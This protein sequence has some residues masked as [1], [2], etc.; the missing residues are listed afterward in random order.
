MTRWVDG[1]EVDS[2]TTPWSLI[3]KSES[4]ETYGSFRR[5][6]VKKA[7]RVDFFVVEAMEIAGSHGHHSKVMLK[8]LIICGF[9]D[10]YNGLWNLN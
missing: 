4:G 1:S 10:L 7:R 2:E 5:R 3:D 9:M 6:L 8:A